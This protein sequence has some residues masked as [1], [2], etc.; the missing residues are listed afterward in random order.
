MPKTSYINEGFAMLKP[1]YILTVIFLLAIAPLTAQRISPFPDE[2]YVPE[3]EQAND[4]AE[5]MKERY[6]ISLHFPYNSYRLDE[7]VIMEVRVHCRKHTIVFTNSPNPFENFKFTLYDS[8]NNKV[9]PS[10]NHTLWEYRELAPLRSGDSIIRINEG[11]YH[12]FKI[13]IYNWF[14]IKKE[15][16]YR[17]RGRFNPTP[18]NTLNFHI[19]TTT[20]YF[21]MDKNAAKKYQEKNE[22]KDEPI[23]IV[24]PLAVPPYDVIENTLTGMQ[25]KSWKEYFRNMHMPSII[26]VS[27]RYEEHYT[28]RFGD[29]EDFSDDGVERKWDRNTLKE[30]LRT[31]FNDTTSLERLARD[32]GTDYT[33][34]LENAFRSQYISNQALTYEILY[35]TALT[36]DKHRIFEE[37][38]RYLASPYDRFLR[39]AFLY[40]LNRN[41][42]YAKTKEEREYAQRLYRAITNETP[43]DQQ[44]DLISF[45]ILK[46]TIEVRDALPTAVVEALLEE[47]YFY[48]KQKHRYLTSVKRYFI[49]KQLGDYW[50]I[51]DY[52]DAKVNTLR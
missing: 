22:A 23:K 11:E 43:S 52:Y 6:F 5:D 50:Y 49:L 28:K 8:K 16:R 25:R 7:A 15:G 45:K 1:T 32:F 48:V 36:K 18:K 26:M 35:R 24:P 30:Y 47:K 17:I 4:D 20:A 44:Y 14:D 46:T 37:Y 42:V 33:N 3:E 27:K 31:N 21:L 2:I 41:A 34:Q 51:V 12:A 9:L 10:F 40:E 19:P 13:N 39:S 38:K 29:N